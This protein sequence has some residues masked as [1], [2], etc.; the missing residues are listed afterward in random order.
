MHK[1][2]NCRL[3]C[4]KISPKKFTS[5]HIVLPQNGSFGAKKIM[6]MKHDQTHYLA[7]M[8]FLFRF[9]VANFSLN[10]GQIFVLEATVQRMP[11]E[12]FEK[13]QATRAQLVF[14]GLGWRFPVNKQSI[15]N[16]YNKITATI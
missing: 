3:C 13:L 6:D 4:S 11:H 10:G 14:T 5:I 8:M 15:I 7:A 12:I 1:Y 16:V 9:G 2:R